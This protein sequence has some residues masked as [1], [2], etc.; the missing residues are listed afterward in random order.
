MCGMCIVIGSIALVGSVI[1]FAS[2]KLA[3]KGSSDEDKE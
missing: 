2:G 1:A 3:G